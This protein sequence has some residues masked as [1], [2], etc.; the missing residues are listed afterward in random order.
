MY[1]HDVYTVISFN[2]PWTMKILIYSPLFYPSIGGVETII[3]VLAHEFFYHGHE[4]KLI[5]QTPSTGPK[6]FPFEVIRQPSVRQMIKLMRWCE[7]Y[8]QG[9]VSIK[10]IYPLFFVNRPLV[11]T[12]QTWYCQ[13]D[14][15]ETWQCYLKKFITRFAINISVSD[16]IARHLPLSSTVIPNS[17]REDVFYAMPEIERSRELVFLGRLVP[18]KGADLLL[19]ALSRLRSAGLRPGLTI[20]G[21]GPEEPSLIQKAKNLNIYDQVSFAGV[22]LEH[23]LARLLNAHQIMVVPSLWDEPFG[24]VALE[25]IACGCAVVGSEGGGLKG[26]IGPCGVTFPN[27][28]VDQLTAILFDLLS[29]PQK[30]NDYRGKAPSHLK[31]H[32]SKAV[33]GAYLDILHE[34]IT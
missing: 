1:N 18:D 29:H 22:K 5:S 14:R 25:G 13:S 21:A 11:I 30:L 8:V 4:V 28:D 3:S 33:A 27:G 32:T 15:S 12:H 19:E 2:Q 24:I 34:A 23:E 20:I 9:C 6:E 7:V 16:A 26:A 10:G 31:A 17:F